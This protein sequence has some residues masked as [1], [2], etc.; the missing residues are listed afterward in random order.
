MNNLTGTGLLTMSAAAPAFLLSRAV[1]PPA[2]GTPEP[3]A[4]QLPW[5]VLLAVLEALV[6]GLGVAF[7]VLAVPAVRR[8]DIRLGVPLWPVYLA[9]GWS[10]VS[11]WPHDRLH[12]STGFSDLNALLGIEYT[13]H[14]SLYAAALVLAWFFV[15][16][17]RSAAQDSQRQG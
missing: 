7:L 2:P 11:W 15:R 6:F 12:Q 5:F 8:R 1:F 3:T 10:L 16:V 4:N 13:F 17:L 9:I 14:V